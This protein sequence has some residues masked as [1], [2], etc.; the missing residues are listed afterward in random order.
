MPRLAQVFVVFDFPLSTAVPRNAWLDFPLLETAPYLAGVV[1]AIA[2]KT[3][4][5]PISHVGEHL[6]ADVV[7]DI[8]TGQ[9]KGDG[10]PLR[11]PKRVYFGGQPALA[12]SNV[13]FAPNFHR[14][15]R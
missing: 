13:A 1:A 11:V 5:L 4:G 7:A 12:S 6:L 9:S 10:P 14:H 2:D 3:L 8:A 15:A